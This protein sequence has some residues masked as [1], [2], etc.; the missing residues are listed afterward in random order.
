MPCSIAYIS[1]GGVVIL[2]WPKKMAFFVG[3]AAAPENNNSISGTK[4]NKFN[5]NL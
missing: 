5:K 1:S 2:P 3:C 4:K